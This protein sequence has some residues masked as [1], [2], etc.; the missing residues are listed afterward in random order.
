LKY[1]LVDILACPICRNFPLELHVFQAEKRYS[2]EDAT[3]CE[4]YCSYH[5]GMVSSLPETRCVECYSYEIIDGLLVCRKCMRWYPVID[6]I[7]IM[8]PDDMRSS[9]RE[10]EFL[11]KWSSRVPEEVLKTGLPF[12]LG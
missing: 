3:P 6:E 9:N 8:L 2:V 5:G 4:I 11:R 7:P 1:R 12:N 10:L